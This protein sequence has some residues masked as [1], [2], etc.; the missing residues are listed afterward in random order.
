MKRGLLGLAVSLAMISPAHAVAGESKDIATL[1]GARPSVESASLS[2]DGQMLLFVQPMAGQ[3]SGAFVA[4]LRGQG[5]LAFKRILVATGDPER[6]DRCEWSS[7][8]R[9]LCHV[10]QVTRLD[11]GD[12]A[13]VDRFIAINADGSNMQMIQAPRGSGAS[14][15]YALYGGRIIDWTGAGDGHV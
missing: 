8:S 14:L 12:L 13:Y 1:F 4:D 2:P 7:N 10:Y 6:M 15:G 9:L 5:K 3:G 11:M